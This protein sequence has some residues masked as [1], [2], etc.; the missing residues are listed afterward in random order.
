[1][2][3]IND[4]HLQGRLFTV[5]DDLPATAKKRLANSWAPIFYNYFFTRIDESV[6]AE[7]YSNKYS[8]PNTPVNILIGF[9]TLKSGFGF[10]DE[11]LYDNFLFNL[12]FRY[13]LGLHEIDE[14]YFNLRTIYNFRSALYRFEQD[15]GRNLIK[16]ATSEITD[17]QIEQLQIKTGIQRMD[18][19]QIQTNIRNMSRIQLLVEI[20]QRVYRILT[21]SDQKKLNEYFADYIKED[22]LHY[23]YRIKRNE[24][25]S[26]L[27]GI[28]KVMAALVEELEEEYHSDEAY[29]H[30]KRVFF[31]HFKV[32]DSHR[33]QIKEGK[34]LSGQTLQSPDDTEATYRRKQNESSKGYVA[35]VTET[36]DPENNIQLI[37]E[38]N[39]KP[40]T[41]DDQELFKEDIERLKQRTEIKKI[42]TDGCYCGETAAEAAKENEVIHRTT[43]IK[44]R[45]KDENKIGLDD[46][47]I[48][49]DN[50]HI[51][52]KITCPNK[53][54]GD[55]KRG[56]KGHRYSAGFDA[57][58][59]ESCPLRNQCPTKILKKKPI[60]ILRFSSKELRVAL[61]RRIIK[62]QGKEGNIRAAVESTIRS[63]IH[64]FGG[65]RCKMPVR[66]KFRISCMIILS[67]MMV[68]IRRLT[69]Y[70]L[71]NGLKF[72]VD[73]YRLT[74][75][76]HLI[77]ICCLNA[78]KDLS[79]SVPLNKH[80]HLWLA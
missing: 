77:D 26:R 75:S 15:T 33:I 24:A 9:E 49:M 44:G 27:E 11:E 65:H 69:E 23:C 58:K 19:T 28:G 34:E 67:A 1:M 14:G 12:Q 47:T 66:G 17:E 5:I 59:C 54:E 30:L 73:L 72:F 13:A 51:P 7:L 38:V 70:A 31:E 53:Q 3:R 37:I 36:C 22:S 45:S 6:F 2:F 57:G 68:N 79:Y 35:N 10:S 32:E 4:E 60:R 80:S 55:I 25:M 21:E 40:N 46:F 76:I 63:V 61:Q 39:V 78:C 74:G 20:I 43:A 18:S 8:R 41:T 16:E 42:W 50:D 56:R 48:E 62:E 52:K 29:K 71:K 64:P